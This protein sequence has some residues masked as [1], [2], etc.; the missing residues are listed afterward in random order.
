MVGACLIAVFAVFAVAAGSASAKDPYT[1]DTWG[2]YKNCPL[3]A[4]G[5]TDCFAGITAGGSKGGSFQFGK[6]TVKL[7]KPIVLQGGFKGGGSEIEVIAPT[8]GAETLEAPELKVAGGLSV[9]S[10]L[11]QEE[12]EWPQALKDSYKE[13]KKNKEAG[14]NVK[15]EVA[16]NELYEVPGGLDTENLLL[17][18]GAAFR[19]PLKVKVTSPWL[20]KL[21]GG[22]CYIGSDAHPIM[23]HLTS[24]D[25]GRAGSLGFN[26]AGTNIEISDSKLVDVGWH[27]EEASGASGC[28]GSEYETFVDNA[29]DKALEIHPWKTGI[30]VLQGNLHDGASSAVRQ[31]AEKGEL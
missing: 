9:I 28:G 3:E 10:K 21:G 24:G 18:E 29:L 2:Q 11:N 22:P 12:A 13:A 16:G 17:E 30:T 31:I 7:N 26:D 20:E 1:V 6:I 19:L 25:A 15:I 8:N 5:I 23:Q 4:P 14:V 27:I